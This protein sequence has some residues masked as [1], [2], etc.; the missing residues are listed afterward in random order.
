VPARREH[1]DAGHRR[2]V[3]DE[4]RHRHVVEQRLPDLGRGQVLGRD[5][6]AR[7]AVLADELRHAGRRLRRLRALEA[8]DDPR[9]AL[10]RTGT[11]DPLEQAPV[12][13]R[14]LEGRVAGADALGRVG[15]T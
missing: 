6:L 11:H 13:R 1:A 2:E 15:E 5:R 7:Q 4:P 9:Q 12:L 10:G 8:L 14:Q 3:A